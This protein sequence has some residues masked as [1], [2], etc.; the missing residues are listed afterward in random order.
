LIRAFNE[1]NNNVIARC[2]RE[3]LLVFEATDGWEPLCKFL[4]KPIP[5]EPYPHI[6][7]TEHFRKIVTGT[8]FA[9][10]AILFFAGAVLIGVTAFIYQ[11]YLN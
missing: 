1:H 5:N 10:S 4:G 2:P 7:D 9:G 8:T 6:N 11:Q 3:K